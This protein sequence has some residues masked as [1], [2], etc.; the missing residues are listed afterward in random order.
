MHINIIGGGIV[1]I[2]TAWALLARGHT[3][4]VFEANE[5]SGLETSFANGGMLTAGM[6][7]PWNAPGVWRDL[8]SSLADPHAAMKLNPSAVPGMAMWGLKFLAQSTPNRFRAN[9]IASYQLCAYSVSLTSQLVPDLGLECD[10]RTGGD[11]KIFPSEDAA[12]FTKEVADMVRPLGMRMDH[13]SRDQVLEKEPALASIADRIACGQYYPDD[14]AGDAHRFTQSLASAV[15]QAGGTIH[16]QTPIARPLVRQ[17][18]CVG[19]ESQSGQEHLADVTIIA[20]ANMSPTLAGKAGVRLPIR[21]VKGYSLTFDVS[22]L[23]GG[24]KLAVIDQAMHAAVNPLGSRLRVAGTAEFTRKPDPVLSQA[25]IDNL[26]QLL[27]ATYPQIAAQLRQE[28]GQGWCGFRP[29]SVDGKPFIG[30]SHV[31]GLY[32][33]SG[34]GYLGWTQATGSAALLSDLVEGKAPAIDPAPYRVDR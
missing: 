32:I 22:H 19:V 30:S 21:P 9:S 24:P 7:E 23:D 25:R 15:T 12:A 14:T 2:S 11:L 5:A 20:A 16:Y 6:S 4:D 10:Y 17:G 13:L 8:L 31:P 3:V 34:H 29:M 28:D 27:Q 18:K 1:G 33:N 26:Y